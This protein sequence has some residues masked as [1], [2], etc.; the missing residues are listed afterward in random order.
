[1]YLIKI[2]VDKNTRVY[3]IVRILGILHPE[4]TTESRESV[5]QDVNLFK[6]VSSFFFFNQVFVIN[7]FLW[8]LRVT[9]KSIL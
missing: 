2:K 6:I 7:Q 9:Q 5:H 8:L 1:M 3:S 4:R